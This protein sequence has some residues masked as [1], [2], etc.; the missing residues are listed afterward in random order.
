M[1]FLLSETI[2]NL[3]LLMM[4]KSLLTSKRLTK[5]DTWAIFEFF[6]IIFIDS[7]RLTYFQP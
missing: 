4:H 2:L 1:I 5:K 6:K 3:M 7:F